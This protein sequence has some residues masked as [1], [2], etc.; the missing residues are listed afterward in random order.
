M[1]N[2]RGKIMEKLLKKNNPEI[3]SKRNLYPKKIKYSICLKEIKRIKIFF[4]NKDQPLH[5]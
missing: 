2:I 4:K 5:I 3:I 1:M